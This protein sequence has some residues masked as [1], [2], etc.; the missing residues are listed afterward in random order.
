MTHETDLGCG[1]GDRSGGSLLPTGNLL[2]VTG[3]DLRVVAELLPTACEAGISCGDVAAG[4]ADWH[5]LPLWGD[6]LRR[7]VR[8]NRAENPAASA[9]QGRSSR[10]DICTGG[11]A[12]VGACAPIGTILLAHGVY[13]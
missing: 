8:R 4:F 10:R 7:C 13:A 1:D 9:V 12:G 3:V 5:C 6:A 11:G 2:A